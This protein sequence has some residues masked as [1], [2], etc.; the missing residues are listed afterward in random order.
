MVEAVGEDERKEVVVVR[1]RARKRLHSGESVEK[2]VLRQEMR[3]N[4][5]LS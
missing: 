2:I 5:S 1:V 3:K 4:A